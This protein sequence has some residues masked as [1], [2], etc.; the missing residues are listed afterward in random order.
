[1]TRWR[2]TARTVV[3]GSSVDTSRIDRLIE[4]SIR[5]GYAAGALAG[6]KVVPDQSDLWVAEFV[7]HFFGCA[8]WPVEMCIKAARTDSQ[9]TTKVL[10]KIG[11]EPTDTDVMRQA[12]EY[13][14]QDGMIDAILRA[15]RRRMQS[16]RVK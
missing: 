6:A 4:E 5:V 10:A 12:Y 8:A 16:N 15:C 9:T 7:M 14:F 11:G 1:M 2:P 3:T 13:A